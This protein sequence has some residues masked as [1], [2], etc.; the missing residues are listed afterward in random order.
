VIV[1][2]SSNINKT[3]ES[4]NSDSQ[5]FP[6]F[7]QN[8]RKFKQWWSTIPPISRKQ[9]KVET[10]IVENSTNINKTKESLNSDGQQFHKYQQNKRKFKQWWSTITVS[11]FFCFLD[12]GGIFDHHCLKFLLFCW[13]WGNC[14]LS[15]F[16]LS[17]V[18]LILVELLTITV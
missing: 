16:T 13:N 10:V 18:W 17:F 6:Q 9:K 5:Q 15:P 11:T 14:W 12:I 1:N 2:N 8:K 3:K 4:L 7:Q